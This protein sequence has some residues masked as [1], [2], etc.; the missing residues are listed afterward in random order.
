MENN[1]TKSEVIKKFLTNSNLKYN[2]KFETTEIKVTT[3]E[4][5]TELEDDENSFIK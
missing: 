2:L 4:I 1:G 5:I 3:E